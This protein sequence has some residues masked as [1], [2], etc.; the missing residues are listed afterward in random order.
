MILPPDLDATTAEPVPPDCLR[1]FGE[2]IESWFGLA[3]PRRNRETLERRFRAVGRATG[4]ANPKELVA[5]LTGAE[6]SSPLF[7]A[8]A[9]LVPNHETSFFRDVEQLHALFD[10]LRERQV[11]GAK[12]PLRILSAGCST[13]EEVYSLA[14]IFFDNIHHFWGRSVAVHGLDLSERAL[15]RGRSGLYPKS[16]LAKAGPGPRDWHQRYFRETERGFQVRPFL[17][18][19]VSFQCANLVDAASLAGLGGFDAVVCRNVLI[20]FEP[21]VLEQTVARL[22]SLLRPGGLLLLGHAES[23]F[24]NH[25]PHLRVRK[26]DN[27]LFVREEE[28]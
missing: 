28:G 5:A 3:H 19:A 2:R 15:S 22:L 17:R 18:E 16:A 1:A 14:M 9:E 13:G 6:V 20:Y 11:P 24:V 27:V 7:R 8:V 23:G 25:L 4:I 21:P 26:G 12:G 10:A